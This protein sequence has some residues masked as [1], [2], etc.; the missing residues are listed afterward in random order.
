MTT[1]A[2][3]VRWP[4][5]CLALLAGA[6]TPA[7]G[8]RMMGGR[9][10]PSFPRPPNMGLAPGMMN[11][12]VMNF[13]FGIRNSYGG[14][15]GNRGYGGSGSS[16]GGGS[17]GAGSYGSGSSDMDTYSGSLRGAAGLTGTDT[18][19][20]YADSPGRSRREP[21]AAEVLSGEALNGLLD[22][23]AA[24][25]ASGLDGLSVPLPG[26]ELMQHIK[27]TGSYDTARLLLLRDGGR[28]EWPESLQAHAFAPARMSLE[29]RTGD[30]ARRLRSDGSVP[31]DVVRGLRAG[32]RSLDADWRQNTAELSPVEYVEARRFIDRLQDAV[33]AVADPGAPRP[34]VGS[35]NPVGRTVAELVA[36]LRAGGLVF[37]PG[38]VGDDA[39]YRALYDA[40]RS[41]D[42]TPSEGRR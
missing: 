14:M 42:T 1:F 38:A 9:I 39:A 20:L 34:L 40:L 29:G 22:R 26:E 27:V 2:T 6:V 32:V 16:Y 7:A 31:A 33:Q 17:Y 41:A 15:Y 10:M 5:A 24:G 4:L 18:R 28:I 19:S 37:A 11:R 36:H 23:L 3:R 25:Q 8:Q 21:T 12:P 35:W 30:A 13:P